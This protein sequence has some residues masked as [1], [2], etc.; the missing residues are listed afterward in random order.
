MLLRCVP[1]ADEDD[2]DDDESESES[3]S[4][5]E[6]ESESETESG[7]TPVSIAGRQ[8]NMRQIYE[9]QSV[10]IDSFRG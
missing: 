4:E 10:L 2:D 8:T 3:V 9:V 5:S 6:S 1:T 7:I